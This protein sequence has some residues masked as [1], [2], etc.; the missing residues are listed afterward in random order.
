MGTEMNPIFQIGKGGINDNL[1]KQ[2]NDALE[3]R[4]I[5]KIRVLTNNDEVP[6]EVANEIVN[7]TDSELVQ[8]IGRNM[9]F[10]RQSKKKS[11]I[12]LP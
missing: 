2:L 6:E 4:E 1:L 3:A 8:L 9:L 12:E 11:Q 10:Y 7:A 5:I